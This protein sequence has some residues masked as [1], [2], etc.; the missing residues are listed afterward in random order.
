MDQR[1]GDLWLWRILALG[2]VLRLVW[3]LLVP[4]EPVSDSAAY[5]TF[6][7][8]L[9]NHGVYGWTP[10][11]P[12]AYWAVGTAA[13]AA[14]TYL[15]FEVDNYTGIVILNLLAGGVSILLTYRLGDL[16]FNRPTAILAALIMA[17]WPN[18]IFF[19]SI[20]S[21]EIWF[22]TLTLGGLWFW[23]RKTGP[24]WINLLF[25]GLIW[26]IACYV[27]PTILLLPVALAL[28]ALPC[29][30]LPL[31]RAGGRAA[32]VIV[33][34]L[35][36]ILPWTQRNTALFGERVLVSTNFGPNLWMGN[37]PDTTG[38]YMPLP[39][40]A[41]DMSEAERATALGDIAK[42]YIRAD[43]PGFVLRSLHKAVQLHERETIGVVWN[44][45][46]LVRGLGEAGNTGLKL[47]ATGFWYLLLL[48]AL[49]AI[50]I[51]FYIS[52]LTAVFHP[53]IAAWGYFTALH[54]VIV[55]EDRYHIPSSPFIALL[56]AFALAYFLDRSGL[57]SNAHRP[58]SESLSR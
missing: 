17:V 14:G 35:I 11:Q 56:A 42:D 58:Q 37:N 5:A 24:A 30:L 36:T 29:G 20:L 47:L 27:R 52:P 28:V 57:L 10:D 34:I 7:R 8:V 19:S 45:A 12:G 51:R 54:A 40:W 33:L 9:A 55:V 43:I 16:W 41:K 46:A 38:G 32:L 15:F 53:T 50:G 25:C 23:S 22:I 2:M 31:L 3:V 4:V 26:G 18:L 21:S 13:I 39:D 48:L 1:T 6:A 49:V 44:E